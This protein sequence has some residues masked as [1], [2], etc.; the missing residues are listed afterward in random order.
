MKSMT[1]IE[2]VAALK[3]GYKIRLA[4]ESVPPLADFI[5]TWEGFELQGS[6]DGNLVTLYK[7]F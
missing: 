3:S 6:Q 2:L 5:K 7:Q 1:I 4:P